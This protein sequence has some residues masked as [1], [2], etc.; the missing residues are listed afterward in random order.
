VNDLP[1][2]MRGELQKHEDITVSIITVSFN[3]VQTIKNT[4]TSVLNQTYNGIEYIIVD[5]GSTDGT[6]EIINAYNDQISCIISEPDNGIYDAINKG[7]KVSN[8][9]IIGILN[10]DDCFCDNI[11]IEKIVRVFKDYSPSTIF[12]D[13]Q[14]FSSAR[15][16]KII[17]YYSSRNFNPN[18][19]KYGFMP[20]HPSF[21]ARRDL[22]NKYGLYKTDYKIAADF[23][24]MTRF[25]YVNNVDYK[26]IEMPFVNM[27]LGGVSNRSIYSRFVL[28]KEILRACRENGIKTNYINIYSKYLRKIFEYWI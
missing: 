8:G 18:K 17:R 10:S 1:S 22:F 20:A 14:F 19:F 6:K 12:G 27:R 23:E 28:N 4:I 11:V 24:L 2:I 21:Y 9:D 3:S 5:G 15:V 25:L 7:I 26:Y 13:A 16:D